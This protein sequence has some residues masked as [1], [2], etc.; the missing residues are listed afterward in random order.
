MSASFKRTLENSSLVLEPYNIEQAGM[1]MA[2]P[3]RSQFMESPSKRTN[4][5]QSKK[6]MNLAEPSHSIQTLT[7]Q[8]NDIV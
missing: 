7:G 4:D 5:C 2:L 1:L 3:K 6:K 8:T